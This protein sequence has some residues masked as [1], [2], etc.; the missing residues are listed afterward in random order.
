LPFTV[1]D[2]FVTIL[3]HLQEAMG[4]DNG[5][6]IWLPG[7]G[8]L[9]T[10]TELR[11][12]FGYWVKVD[13]PLALTYPP[14]G[15]GLDPGDFRWPADS[16]FTSPPSTETSRNWMSV[17]GEGLSIDGQPL[18]D[19]SVITF[20]TEGDVVCG[21]G[22]YANGMLRFTPIYGRDQSGDVSKSY[23]VEGDVLAVYVDEQRVYPDVT[24]SSDGARVRLSRLTTDSR[25]LPQEY[26]LAQNYPNPFNPGTMVA[27]EVPV[28]GRVNIAIFNV[29][30]QQVRTLTNSDYV[31]G[32]YELE[33]NGRDDGGEP[34]ASGVY[35]YRLT[36]GEMVL[37]KKM[38]LLK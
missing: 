36:A 24:W 34:V 26:E 12:T 38:M 21:H 8:N 3:D 22:V 35:F 17:Y 19:G 29:L 15:G 1:E 10:L 32:R 7:L 9:N 11:P 18:A 25:G 27:F 33:W 5:A 20:H 23:P 13:A 2:G 14:F 16:G 31:V 6:Q 4:F 30:G 28:D 37:T